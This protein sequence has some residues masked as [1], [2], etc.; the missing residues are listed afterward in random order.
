MMAGLEAR[1]AAIAAEARQRAIAA[2]AERIEAELPGV[3]VA[4]REE[5][6]V[7]S[8]RGLARRLIDEPV[9]RWIGSLVR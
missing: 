1:G 8:G 4:P 3:A 5:G 6:V 9:L 7:L 2:L